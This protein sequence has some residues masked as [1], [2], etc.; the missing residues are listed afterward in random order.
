MSFLKKGLSLLLACFV[1]FSIIITDTVQ[2]SNSQPISAQES[3]VIAQIPTVNLS[4]LPSEA[5]STLKL[6]VLF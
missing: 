5:R 1:F 2:S 4:Q 6:F 3:T